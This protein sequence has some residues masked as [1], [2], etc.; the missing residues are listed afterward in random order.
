MCGIVGYI[1]ARNA[2]EVLLDGLKR[3]EYRGYD[4]AG[5]ALHLNGTLSED[6][7]VI[8]RAGT[9]SEGL[10]KALGEASSG[11]SSQGIGHTRWA[12]HG[13]PNDQNAHP[14]VDCTGRIA[15][16]HNGII[17]NYSELRDELSESGHRFT[18]DTDTEVIPHLIEQYR[19]EGLD[20]LEAVRCAAARLEGAYALAVLDSACPDTIVGVRRNSPL[21]VGLGQDE[22][23]L[24]SDVPAVLPYTREIMILENGDMAL[25]DRSGVSV[26]REDAGE[27]Q[28]GVE[29]IDWDPVLAEREGYPHFMLKEIEEQPKAW[30]SA[31]RGRLE[32]GRPHLPELSFE[33]GTVEGISRVYLVGCGTSYHAGT[34]AAPLFE[35]FMGI[36]ARAVI[37]SEFRYGAP[38]LGEDSLVVL[39]SQSGE[40]A[41]TLA[42]LDLAREEDCPTVVI[43]NAVGSSMARG[44]DNVLYTHA[45]PEISVASTK[46]YTA[47]ML[48]LYLLAC[49]L[50][51]RR[52]A[53]RVV[54]VQELLGGVEQLSDSAE[55]LLSDTDEIME[56]ARYIAEWEDAFFIGRGLDYTAA[57]EGQLKLK[58]IS[59]I[60]AE[61]YPA[62]ELKHGTLALI[63]SGI[64]VIAISTQDGLREKMASNVEEVRARGGWVALVTDRPEERTSSGVDAVISVPELVPEVSPFLV[65][66][67]LQLLAYHAAVL[68]D[69]PVDK[70]RN[71]A[72]SVTVE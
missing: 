47:Q 15:V 14:H 30:R 32:D 66:V 28:R 34:T 58:E 38:L 46:T 24:A 49:E 64:P 6:I 26:H 12:T 44:A 61:A 29:T 68:R 21:I 13:V 25:V 40:T 22:M 2:R 16:V 27:I 31:L 71:L 53:A 10:E 1:G 52:G 42:C 41:D 51:L 60:H 57:M 33:K 65:G 36:P 67:A 37:G 20:L 3:L 62:G 4:S 70:P 48:L 35:R 17:E 8:K 43:S 54:D 63:E 56:V 69:C 5:L 7:Q 55:R 59:Y 19:G 45:G 23:F 11:H 72:K 9:I 18:S 39:I 50:G